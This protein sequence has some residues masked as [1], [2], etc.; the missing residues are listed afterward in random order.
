VTPSIAYIKFWPGRPG[1]VDASL[2][3]TGNSSIE[4]HT[5]DDRP[6]ILSVRDAHVS[7]SVTVP[8]SGTVTAEDIETARRL[9]D[10]VARYIADLERRLPAEAPAADGVAA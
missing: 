3:L 8:D 2:H 4:C 1:E 9:A 6:A 10:A 5:Y 7:V